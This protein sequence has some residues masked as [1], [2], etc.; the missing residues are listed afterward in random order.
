ML[1]HQRTPNFLYCPLTEHGATVLGWGRNACL[2]L[3]RACAPK[4]NINRLRLTFQWLRDRQPALTSKDLGRNEE[5]AAK[6]LKKLEEVG[7]NVDNFGKTVAQ[8][9]KQKKNLLDQKNSYGQGK[10]GKR[11]M[12]TIL[13]K[14][15]HN[16]TEKLIRLKS[17]PGLGECE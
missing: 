8:L 10:S 4:T 11:K 5:S 16:S 3:K 13:A 12:L 2:A 17:G 7:R 9:D 14:Q 1:D 6:L 15:S